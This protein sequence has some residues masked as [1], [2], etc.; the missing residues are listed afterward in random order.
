MHAWTLTHSLWNSLIHSLT[1]ILTHSHTHIDSHLATAIWFS[2][3]TIILAS[4]NG[5]GER[6]CCT[7]MQ[8][9]SMPR[10]CSPCNS[11]CQGWQSLLVHMLP[12]RTTLYLPFSHISSSSLKLEWNINSQNSEV[13]VICRRFVEISVSL[14]MNWYLTQYIYNCI[15]INKRLHGPPLV[16]VSGLQIGYDQNTDLSLAIM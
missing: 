8:V 1:L 14:L 4:S 12:P 5:P 2:F 11:P 10:A 7:L 15:F 6:Y 13:C 9:L 16:T 3:F